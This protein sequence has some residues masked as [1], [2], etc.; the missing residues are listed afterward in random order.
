MK[1]H[2]DSLGLFYDEKEDRDRLEAL[3]F[4]FKS[5]STYSPGKIRMRKV[6]Q[7]KDNGDF[8]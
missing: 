4:K 6:S 1:F 7:N 2:I 3:G 5:D 8:N